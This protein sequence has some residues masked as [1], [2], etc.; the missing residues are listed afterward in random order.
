MWMSNN[1][2][3]RVGSMGAPAGDDSW[4]PEDGGPLRGFGTG[5]DA[6]A[7]VK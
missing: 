2:V 7:G 1:G 4:L 6:G 5:A 3:G